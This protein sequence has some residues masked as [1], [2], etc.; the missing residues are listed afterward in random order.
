LIL[1]EVELFPCIQLKVGRGISLSTAH[2]WLCGEGFQYISH[3]KGL[4]FDGHDHPDVLAYWQ[5]DFL[6]KMKSFEP[7]LVCYIVGDVEKKVPPSN[8]VERHLVLCS[9]DE[10][11]SQANDSP[12]K[13]WVLRDK[14]HLQ[15]KSVGHELHHRD[16]ICSTVGWLADASQTFEYGKNYKGYWTGELFV[17]QVGHNTLIMK[18]C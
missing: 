1:T 13:A 18:I 6:P 9:H 14:H 15:K 11:T 5:N 2:R 17:K 7:V 4:Y 8:F 3:K 16:V 12:A 10:S